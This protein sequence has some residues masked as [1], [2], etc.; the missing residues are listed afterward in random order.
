MSVLRRIVLTGAVLLALPVVS[1][2]AQENLDRGK[3][4]QQMFASDCAVCHKSPQGLASKAGML[5]L[6]EFLRKHY[7][8]SRESAQALADYLSRAGDAPAA[9]PAA[10]KPAQKKDAAKPADGKPAEAKPD[11]KPDAKP[12]DAKAKAEEKKDEAPKATPAAASGAAPKSE[13]FP[14]VKPAQPAAKPEKTE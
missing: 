11:A 2:R 4:P 8:A 3:S 10:K 1:V 13:P 9:K 14:D 12:A 7:T 5:G 6:Q